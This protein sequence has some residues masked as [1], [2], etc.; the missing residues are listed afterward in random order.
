MS[1]QSLEKAR[2]QEGASL[3]LA[4]GRDASEATTGRLTEGQEC[5]Q[6]VTRWSDYRILSKEPGQ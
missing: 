1:R 4:Q 6:Y 3:H 2:R 5:D